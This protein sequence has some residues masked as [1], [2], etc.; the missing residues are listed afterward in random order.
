MKTQKWIVTVA[1]FG[2]TSGALRS[3]SRAEILEEREMAIFQAQI[4]LEE[5][6]ENWEGLDE[7]RSQVAPLR[8]EALQVFENPHLK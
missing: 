5:S 7:V 8:E 4:D 3:Q 1:L 2:L 6:V